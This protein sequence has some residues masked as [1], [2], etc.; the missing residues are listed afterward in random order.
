MPPLVQQSK[1][2]GYFEKYGPISSFEKEMDPVTGAALGIVTIQYATHEQARECV[3][4]EDGKRYNAGVGLGLASSMGKGVEEPMK[5]VFDGEGMKLKAVLAEVGERSKRD[6]DEKRRLQA[7]RERGE[8]GSAASLPNGLQPPTGTSQGAQVN[9]HAIAGLPQRLPPPRRQ[10]PPSLVRARRAIANYS[11][12]ASP[13]PNPNSAPYPSLPS[14]SLTHGPSATQALKTN[15]GSHTTSSPR[16]SSSTPIHPLPA[17]PVTSYPHSRSIS[18][19]RLS[20]QHSAHSALTAE[21]TPRPSRSPSP[22]VLGLPRT[23]KTDEKLKEER[24]TERIAVLRELANNGKEHVWIDGS[25][26]S[27]GAVTED[28]VRRFFKQLKVEQVSHASA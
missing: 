16:S 10:P 8:I 9:G 24:E 20:I 18:H 25:Q 2:K 28:D 12:N 7:M 22:E 17:R 5:V 19:S 1:L 14:N 6:R 27:G 4:K 23:S 15:V 11:D 21:S 26:L 13:N 3:A